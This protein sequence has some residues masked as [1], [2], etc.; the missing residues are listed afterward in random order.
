VANKGPRKQVGIAISNKVDFKLTLVKQD[1]VH[2]ILIK[3]AIQQE[4]IVNLDDRV[5]VHLL[6]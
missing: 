1:K 2:F 6:H 4:G 5:L 3:R